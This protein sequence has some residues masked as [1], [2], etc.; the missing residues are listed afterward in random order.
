MSQRAAQGFTLTELLV[1]IGIL[2]VLFWM[3]LPAVQAARE[4]V[5]RASCANRLIQMTIAVQNYEDAIKAYSPGTIDVQGPIVNLLQGSLRF[6]RDTIDMQVYQRLG[7]R[8]D[9]QLLS[10]EF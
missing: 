1:V 7:H 6:I 5:R 10:E 2:G 4:G 9:G 8:A 3:L